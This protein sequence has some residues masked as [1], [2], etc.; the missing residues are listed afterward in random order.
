[1]RVSDDEFRAQVAAVVAD[2]EDLA[3]GLLVDGMLGASGRVLA[4][5]QVIRALWARLNPPPAQAEPEQQAPVASE[6]A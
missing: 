3:D 1:M 2:L 5:R 4:G 6:V